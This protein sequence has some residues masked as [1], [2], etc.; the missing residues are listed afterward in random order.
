L[1]AR[2]GTAWRLEEGPELRFGNRIGPARLT[3]ACLGSCQHED[4]MATWKACKRRH[5]DAAGKRRHGEGAQ[6]GTFRFDALGQLGTPAFWPRLE[7]ALERQVEP[8]G[9]VHERHEALALVKR[10]GAVLLGSTTIA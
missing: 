3:C 2:S 8:V 4:P 7:D 9:R 5:G 1:E 6:T 10:F